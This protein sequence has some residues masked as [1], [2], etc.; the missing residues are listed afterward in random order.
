MN[1]FIID[2]SWCGFVW[3]DLFGKL[4]CGPVDGLHPDGLAGS[5]AA[6]GE[7]VLGGVEGEGLH[8]VSA[9]PEELPV[10]LAHCLRVLHRCL[11]GPGA[12]LHAGE[13]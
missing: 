8:D 11:R 2:F 10:Q 6:V 3:P 13:G 4:G 1:H 9:C 5:V 12:G 7:L